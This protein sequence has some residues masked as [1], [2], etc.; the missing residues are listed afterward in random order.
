M[1]VY[2]LRP[3]L[4]EPYSVNM[5]AHYLVHHNGFN[6]VLLKAGDAFVIDDFVS[7]DH[8]VYNLCMQVW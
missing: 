4:V 7:D 1:M 8:A 2:M 5:L 3:N 6:N